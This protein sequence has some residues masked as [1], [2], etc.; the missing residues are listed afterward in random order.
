M[1]ALAA[2][3]V[4]PVRG[5]GAGSATAGSG[6]AAGAAGIGWGGVEPLRDGDGRVVAVLG[7]GVSGMTWFPFAG[8]RG[9]LASAAG[10]DAG[11]MGEAALTGGH[12]GRR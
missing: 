12:Q 9:V 4:S 6:G 5:F 3:V 8:G 11:G 1:R 10:R 2:L 7:W